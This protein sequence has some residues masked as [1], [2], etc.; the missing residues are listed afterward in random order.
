M[1]SRLSLLVSCPR[2]CG[3]ILKKELR[4][5]KCVTLETTTSSVL[6][7]GDQETIAQIN[8]W[9]RVANRVGVVVV[10]QEM[11]DYDALFDAV[12]AVDRSQYVGQDRGVTVYAHSRS[13]TLQSD[14]TTQSIVHKAVIQSLVGGD[15]HR[16]IDDGKIRQTVSVSILQ[17]RVQVVVDASGDALYQRGYRLDTGDAPIKENVAAAILLSLGWSWRQPLL[18][19]TC[20]SGTFLI[21]AAMMAINRAPGLD[22]L[23]QCEKWPCRSVDMTAKRNDAKEKLFAG[24]EYIFK[25]SDRDM[26]MIAYAKA[27]AERAGVADVISWE[28]KPLADWSSRDGMVV[29]NPPYGLRLDQDDVAV[30]HEDLI[31][32]LEKEGV[33]GGFITSHDVGKMDLTKWKYEKWRNGGEEVILRK[34]K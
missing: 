13:S 30:V 24:K 20:G 34:R 21:E 25:G 12:R 29:S 4:R 3:Q 11:T 14:R 31:Y 16:N 15:G 2:G 28:T 10:D 9:S 5:L 27:N 32:L 22:R 18:D 7:E 1:A 23:F 17:N 6:V 8:L 33:R 26:K 19:P